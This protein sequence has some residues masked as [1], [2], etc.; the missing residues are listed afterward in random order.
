MELTDEG[1]RHVPLLL[2]GEKA[3]I[4]AFT[5]TGK[6]IVQALGKNYAAEVLPV[7]LKKAAAPA[8]G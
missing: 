3:R 5:S 8:G 2:F 4:V 7:H 6:A 1:L